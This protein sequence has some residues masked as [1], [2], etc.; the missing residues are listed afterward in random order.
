MDMVHPER[1]RW[2]NEI[3]A[4]NREINESGEET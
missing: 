3:A 1:R 4:I 2:V